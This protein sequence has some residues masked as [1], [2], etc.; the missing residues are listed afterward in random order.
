MTLITR[1]R[2]LAVKRKLQVIIMA[3]V[4]V[5]LLA[6]CGAILTY[7]Q[8]ELRDDSQHDLTT[9]AV[10]YGA[11]ATAAL[12][13]GDHQAAAEL[14]ASLAT[15][16]EI[17]S[18][19]IYSANGDA[20]AQYRRSDAVNS[21]IPR[22]RFNVIW[23]EADRLKM[24]QQILLEKQP[25][26][27]IY[28]EADL[29]DAHR[30]L[31]R[32]GAVL[33]ATLL[34]ASGLAFLLASRLQRSV[35]QPIQHLAETARLVSV[36][37]DFT[38]RA[39][40]MAE[41]DLGQLT[42]TFNA[43][44]GE[45]E[46]RD[47]ELLAHQDHLEQEVAKRTADLVVAKDR[48]E[49]AN[50]AKSEFLANMSH[51]IRTPMNGIIGMTELALD[52]DLSEQ[53]RDY[54]KT[55]QTSGESLLNI[56][57]D[58][59]DFSKI[60]AGKFSLD[61]AEFNLDELLQDTIRV[62][63]V[64]AQE[65]GLELLYDN[66]SALPELVVGDAGRLRQ[67]VVNLLGNAVKFT[68]S[69]EVLLGVRE[70][71]QQEQTLTVHFVVSDTGIG[72]SKEWKERIFES[73]VQA[74]GSN[75]RRHGGTGLGLAIC[76]RVVGLMGG[77]IWVESEAGKGS[78][79]HFTVNFGA[80]VSG[81]RD[82][83]A[84]D[85]DVLHGLEVLV[86]DDNAT[87]RRILRETL[88]KWRMRPTVA[89]SGT[90]ALDILRRR[91][92]L[93]EKFDV[94]LLDGQMPGMDGFAVAQ[95]IQENPALAG[96]KIMMLSSVDV[97]ALR[98]DYMGLA[99]YVLKPVTRANLLKAIL[100]VVGKRP[101]TGIRPYR[102]AASDP[103]KPFLVL[104]AEDNPVNQRV[105]ALILKKEGHSVVLVSNGAAAVDASAL[106]PFDLILM[107]VQM[108]VM[109]GY[110]ATRAIREREER[111][112]QHTPIVALTA[113][114]TKGERETCLQ[115]GMDDYLSK[116]IRTPE[117]HEMVARWSGQSVLGPDPLPRL[118][119]VDQ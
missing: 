92:D 35:S 72:I 51:E 5:A 41:D 17:I 46:R 99:D 78:V 32:S 82:A 28:L 25:I 83:Q 70:I 22:I 40:K 29:E 101:Q 21:T 105:V 6:S 42:D 97:P 119:K 87:N 75:T 118:A 110:E 74:D 100:K 61:V 55:V 23:F 12:T 90:T 68:V 39:K 19:V 10:V 37:K 8:F 50:R 60:E 4:F 15:Q 80:A 48:A 81:R 85:P 59:L 26:G 112:N 63:A 11:N 34:G 24:F 95:C 69:G 64:Q 9:L 88:L 108:P 36:H 98:K 86:V 53:Q 18:A 56:I 49:S 47:A 45:I 44:L 73:F 13:F 20:V 66:Q 7:I 102:P 93:G 54:L 16:R 114:A 1:Y 27:V 115:A 116:P 33:L 76:S 96:P 113:H 14:L 79:F 89:D 109:D 71:R 31:K 107:D 117:L 65:K 94:V 38:T 62:V 58:I 3:T 67:I 106:E 43:M 77:R 52:T 111:T 84:S 30:R 104:V 91:A 103:G 2:N 57:N